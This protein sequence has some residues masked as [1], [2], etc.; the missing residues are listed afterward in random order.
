MFGRGGNRSSTSAVSVER[1]RNSWVGS[2]LLSG[3]F[4]IFLLAG[5]AGTYF[6]FVQP[7]LQ[8]S[9]AR[10][11]QT[12]P[13]VIIS[14]EVEEHADNDGSTYSVK[15]TYKYEIDGQEFQSDRYKFMGGSSSGR[16]GKQA[17]VDQYPAGEESKCFVDPNDPSEAVLE[18][19]LTAD[20]LFGLIPLV[21]VM[22]GAGGLLVLTGV[23]N[24]G[25]SDK[26]SAT[27]QPKS[28]RRPNDSLESHAF[29]ANDSGAPLVLEPAWSPIGR[30]VGLLFVA[31]FWNGIVSVFVWQ[32]YQGF[33][34]GEPEWFLTIFMIPFVLIGIAFVGGVF[35]AV[36]MLWNPRLTI[37]LEPGVVRLGE[38]VRMSWNFS[39]NTN[40]IRQLLIQLRGTEE[41]T[42]R[43]GTSTYTDKETFFE[44]DLIDTTN[45]MDILQGETE[46]T[47]PSNTMHSFE[48]DHNEIT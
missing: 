42:Y 9:A 8:V 29:D 37:T 3:L 32:V 47:V 13:C 45:P 26:K 2:A 4:S 11:W 7:L 10:N 35:H 39:G 12:V 34:K 19:G 30:I 31:L 24:L 23:V 18:R 1:H 27:W 38:T 43:R 20:M 25:S 28:L 48:S 14:S 40:S 21:F 46:F 33:Q 6:F 5:S 22:V 44:D 15:I 16:A 41:A 17:V 36:L